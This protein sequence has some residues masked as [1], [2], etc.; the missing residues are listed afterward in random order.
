MPTPSRRMRRRP[1]VAQTSP[2]PQREW[3]SRKMARRAL[4][5][6]PLFA[7]GRRAGRGIHSGARRD[8]ERL[9]LDGGERRGM[10]CSVNGTSGNGS[11]VATLSV[12]ENPSQARRSRVTIGGQTLTIDQGSRAVPPPPAR[13]H[14]RFRRPLR[15]PVRHP[16]RHRRQRQPRRR[17]QHPPRRLPRRRL[18]LQRLPRHQLQHPRQLRLHRH[19]LRPP[20]LPLRQRPRTS[21]ST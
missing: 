13:L 6:A 1:H 20:S 10:D 16:H 21:G 2:S 7:C 11:G 12:A 15:H 18:Q 3:R 17:F 14:P 19:H 8:D 9:Y 5:D 4:V